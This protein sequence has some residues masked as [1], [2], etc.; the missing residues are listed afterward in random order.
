MAHDPK[1]DLV[2]ERKVSASPAQ[3]WRAWT[4]PDLLKQWF[5]P[6]PWT[7]ARVAIDV[8]P[9]GIFSVVMASPEGEAMDET[10]GCILLAQSERRL[11]WT[12]AVGP[13]FRPNAETFM[14]V[15]IT[16][17]AVDGGAWYRAVVRH[18][19]AADRQKHEEMGFHEG[20]G[21]CLSQL[22]SLAGQL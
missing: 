19:S 7:V 3:L 8:R 18:K 4:E 2:L 11:V 6:K 20:W 15:D 1:L 22:E 13:D 14:S 16:I 21:T 9:G 17:E 5:A 10:P 12:D